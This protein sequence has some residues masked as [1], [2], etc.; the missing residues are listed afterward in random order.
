[1]DGLTTCNTSSG[2]H[3]W[4]CQESTLPKSSTHRSVLYLAIALQYDGRSFV[5]DTTF[6][7]LIERE[8]V[9]NDNGRNMA[10]LSPIILFYIL[11]SGF[12]CSGL[13]F[14][15]I[16]Y[17]PSGPWGRMLLRCVYGCCLCVPVGHDV[18]S[19][20]YPSGP[21]SGISNQDYVMLFVFILY[22][23]CF[24]DFVFCIFWN[25][26]N[27]YSEICLNPMGLCVYSGFDK[28]LVYEGK[29]MWRHVAISIPP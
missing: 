15:S 5:I 16:L 29:Q 17:C 19:D 2:P 1:M 10:S 21:P 6:I 23:S 18:E 14:N 24:I 7:S 4:F 3:T 12:L 25:F 8:N 26:N 20:A 9:P 27:Q 22:L 28:M 13:Y 11:K